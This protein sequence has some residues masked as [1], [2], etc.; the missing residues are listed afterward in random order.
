MS[1]LTEGT[2]RDLP[3]VESVEM[4]D[5]HDDEVDEENE[6]QH[7][8]TTRGTSAAW[9]ASPSR[10]SLFEPS[11]QGHSLNRPLNEY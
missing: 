5:D 3:A 7:Q 9:V 11:G 10:S 6:F 1:P 2:Q 8:V 4:D